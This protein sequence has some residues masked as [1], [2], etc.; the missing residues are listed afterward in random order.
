VLLKALA[1]ERA[2]RYATV[3]ELSAAFLKA[4]AAP[5]SSSAPRADAAE[6]LVGAPTPPPKPPP[7]GRP[8][9]P[10]PTPL[11]SPSTTPALAPP[12]A[13]VPKARS[14][15][16]WVWV[17]AGL[18]LTLLCL[19]L[20]IAV[21][22]NQGD[23][24]AAPP[25]SAAP[26]VE[27]TEEVR[28]PGV[29]AAR[30]T[31]AARPDDPEAYFT[32]AEAEA[33]AGFPLLA[34]RDYRKA[35]D[36]FLRARASLRAS[37][38]YLK[39]IVSQGGPD[40]V[41][42]GLLDS[43]LKAALTAGGEDPQGTLAL[44]EAA[45][46][47][48]PDWPPLLMI[49]AHAQ[50]AADE[51]DAAGELIDRALAQNPQDGL[52]LAVQAELL[53]E[54]GDR[55]G[56]RRA[57]EAAQATGTVPAWLMAVLTE[58]LAGPQAPDLMK[59][60]GEGSGPGLFMDARS[61]GMDEAGRIYVAEYDG[62]RVQVFDKQGAFLTQWFADREAPLRAIAVRRDGEVYTGQG[63]AIVLRD[64]QSGEALSR[65]GYVQ[66][67]IFNDV[68]LLPDGRLLTAWYRNR[69]DIAVL[70]PGGKTLSAIEGVV[71]QQTG[72]PELNLRV[73]SDGQSGLWVL[74]EFSSAVFHFDGEGR[75]INRFG[76]PGDEPGQLSSPQSLAVDG[77][78]RIYVGDFHGVQVFAADGRF[79]GRIEVEG[80][81]YGLFIDP[82]GRLWVANGTYVRQYEVGLP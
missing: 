82:G 28:D 72:E 73:A 4:V 75:F 16:P 47:A 71:S 64:G 70:D 77:K 43:A 23:P 13:A 81:C 11:P 41:E 54:T 33:E 10:P 17:A 65:V 35:A 79:I 53:R 26:G 19:L 7:G 50:I 27:A 46:D 58:S 15:R 42:K 22:S 8:D 3:E 80:P 38:A 48:L 9:T 76:S 74:G 31:L 61:L 40:K 62:G 34:A 66:G 20:L 1:K 18:G 21:A 5:A 29:L 55:A 67:S 37:A 52:A 56:A 32:L 59:I 6:T 45:A 63:G 24:Q 2:D 57:A 51:L 30:A 69:D 49:A 39:A 12:P 68:A 36:L 60:G 14:K 25:A 78:G 44:I